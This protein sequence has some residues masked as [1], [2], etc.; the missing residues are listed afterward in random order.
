MAG[1]K[2]R[3]GG[4]RPNSGGK[5]EGAGRPR[6]KADP[7]AAASPVQVPYDGRDPLQFLLDVMQGTEASALQVR[8]AIAAAQ[9]T[10]VKKH[11]GGKKEEQQ[12]K[13]GE[14]AGVGKFKPAAPPRLVSSG[15]G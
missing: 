3:S 12:A 5:R 6:T 15:G 7:L 2:G 14:A 10:S 8:A 1:V 9:Y 11:D 4:P 13:A